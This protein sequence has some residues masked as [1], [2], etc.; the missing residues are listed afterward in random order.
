MPGSDVSLDDLKADQDAALGGDDD[1]D[2]STAEFLEKVF[3]TL[4]ERGYLDAMVAQQFDLDGVQSGTGET[5]DVPA[6]VDPDGGDPT[7]AASAGE[8]DAE[9]VARFGKLVIDNM[10]DVPMSKVVKIAESN[11]QTV[12]QVIQQATQGGVDGAD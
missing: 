8:V 11:P 5:G 7:G 10:G 2:D 9:A 1:S 12:N 6:A 4:D 3:D